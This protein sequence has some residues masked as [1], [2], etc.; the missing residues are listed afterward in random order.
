M[1]VNG[2]QI[3]LGAASLQDPG[4][5]GEGYM[6]NNQFQPGAQFVVVTPS[7]DW[8]PQGTGEGQLGTEFNTRIVQYT[9]ARN[10]FVF[11]FPYGDAEVQEGQ[12]YTLGGDWEDIQEQADD[13][14]QVNFVNV[15]FNPV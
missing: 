5:G 10:Q 2:N 8:A 13:G 4:R 1:T 9:G 3:D 15:T 7:L 14:D 12:R 6:F 11:L